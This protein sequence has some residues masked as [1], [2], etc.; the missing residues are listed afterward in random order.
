MRQVTVL[1]QE[2]HVNFPVAVCG[3]FP[4]PVPAHFL[5]TYS[6]SLGNLNQNQEFLAWAGTEI[7][8]PLG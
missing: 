8:A 5:C 7:P 6:K 2:T 3:V 4:A 1:S